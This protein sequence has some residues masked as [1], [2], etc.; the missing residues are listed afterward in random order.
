MGNLLP[1][2]HSPLIRIS[3]SVWSSDLWPVVLCPTPLEQR[4]GGEMSPHRSPPPLPHTSTCRDQH[5]SVQN[6]WPRDKVPPIKPR[7]N[8]RL[9]IHKLLWGILISIDVSNF[10]FLLWIMTVVSGFKLSIGNIHVYVGDMYL[11]ILF[12]K[13]DQWKSKLSIPWHLKLTVRMF[14]ANYQTNEVIGQKNLLMITIY[15]SST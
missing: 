7:D 3:L 4:P 10:K 8:Y 14:L 2:F 11:S 12:V 9:R 1:F 5:D 6:L 13:K 15:I